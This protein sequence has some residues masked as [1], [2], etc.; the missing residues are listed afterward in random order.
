MAATMKLADKG[1]DEA[2]NRRISILVLNKQTEQ[3]ILHENAD[4]ENGSLSDLA[5]P[6]AVPPA[7]NSTPPQPGQR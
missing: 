2:I 5:Q 4:S 6:G 7:T 1:P 3:S